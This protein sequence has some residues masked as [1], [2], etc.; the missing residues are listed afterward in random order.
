MDLKLIQNEVNATLTLGG[1]LSLV[2]VD[3]L[4]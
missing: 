2:L 3:K 4:S 1:I